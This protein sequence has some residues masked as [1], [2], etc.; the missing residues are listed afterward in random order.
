MQQSPVLQHPPGSQPPPWPQYPRDTYDSVS[1]NNGQPSS[2]PSSSMNDR[3]L[4]PF[5][6]IPEEDECPICHHELP[7]RALPNFEAKREQ[8]ITECIM[9]HSTY[10]YQTS[11]PDRPGLHGTPPPRV[12][13]RTGMFAYTAT[14]KDCANLDECTICLEEYE[15]GI[16]MAR[17]ECLCRFHRACIT[18]WF[19]KN[20]GRCPIHQHDSLGY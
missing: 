11:R 16:P 13:R 15:V 9:S 20:P 6:Q 10:S 2:F 19:I 8:H 5:P 18:E 17:L 3:P 1:R 14:E 7:S 12:A 4:P